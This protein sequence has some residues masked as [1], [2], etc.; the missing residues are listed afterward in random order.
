MKK[1]RDT[2]NRIRKYVFTLLLIILVMNV[3]NCYDK[4]EQHRFHDNHTYN[5]ENFMENVPHLIL[6][7]TR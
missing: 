2:W 5:I 6:Y 7:F 1:I 4:Y 3:L